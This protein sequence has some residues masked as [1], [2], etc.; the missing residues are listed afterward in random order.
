MTSSVPTHAVVEV[1]SIFGTIE[2]FA[3]DLITDHIVAFGAHTRP[4]LAFLLAVVEPGDA[5]FDLGAHIGSFTI[6]LARRIGE[7]GRIV[8][9]E[10]LP[11]TFALLER[12]LRR[13]AAAAVALNALVAPSAQTYGVQT[14]TGNT[15]A[16]YFVRD[17]TRALPIVCVTLDALCERWFVPRVVKLDLEGFEAFA[18]ASAP[19]LLARRPIIYAEV[20]E[21]QLRRNGAGVN[22]LERLLGGNGYRYFRNVGE[23]NAPHDEYV[24]AELPSLAAGGDFFDVLAIHRDDPRLARLLAR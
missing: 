14:P 8:A 7:A 4:E 18:L 21:A 17:P 23:R 2:A 1:D 12:N 10:G 9:V 15:G 20:A 6:P 16:S 11:S 13:H 19:R 3:G 22:E 24:V 5:V